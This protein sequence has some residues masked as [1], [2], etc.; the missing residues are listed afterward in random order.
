MRPNDSITLIKEESNLCNT[1]SRGSFD[2]CVDFPHSSS[3]GRILM[4]ELEVKTFPDRRPS[5]VLK[6]RHGY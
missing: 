5:N 4:V 3:F 1:I 2:N 6:A